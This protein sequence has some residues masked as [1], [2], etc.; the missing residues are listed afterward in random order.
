MK[1][2]TLAIDDGLLERARVY[3]AVRKTTVNGLVRELL[4][5]AVDEDTRIVEARKKLKALMERSTLELGPDF[6]WNREEIYADRLLP[7]HERPD[8]RGGDEG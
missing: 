7:R 4:A 1:N 8:L 5:Q 3:A 6:V 2:I